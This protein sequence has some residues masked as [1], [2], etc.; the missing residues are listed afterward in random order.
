MI[1]SMRLPGVDRRVFAEGE[2]GR[3]LEAHLAAE[4]GAQMRRRRLEGGLRRHPLLRLEL[5]HD[6]R[7]PLLRP[8]ERGI[9]DGR[10]SEV[11]G[12]RRR[13]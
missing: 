13:R 8:P 2:L 7:T 5:R 11:G 6:P 3:V 9:V 12:S 10:L 4:R 1:A